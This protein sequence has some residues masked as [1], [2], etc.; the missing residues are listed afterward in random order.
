M[1]QLICVS[2]LVL[3]VVLI[4]ASPSLVAQ[5]KPGETTE[6]KKPGRTPLPFHFGKVG[7]SDEQKEQLYAIQDSYKAKIE[8]LQQ[9]IKDL[10]KEREQKM[11]ALLTD[12]QKARF[13]ELK[14]EAAQRAA[15]AEA[16]AEAEACAEAAKDQP[17]AAPSPGIP[18]VEKTE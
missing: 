12:G 17:K 2:G 5:P 10:L 6:V 9:Q 3:L 18:P 16:E 11:T 13:Q 8:P 1:K 14:V 7:V 15:E 4:G